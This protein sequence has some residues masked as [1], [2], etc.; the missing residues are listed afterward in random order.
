[1]FYPLL[2]F[3]FDPQPSTFN[4]QPS[5]LNLQLSTLNLQLSTLNL[6]LSTLNLQL[7]TLSTTHG[8]PSTQ[9]DKITIPTHLLVVGLRERSAV[10]EDLAE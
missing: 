6:Q 4:P 3:D 7:S 1:M 2:N 8:L 10:V 5:T 9:M